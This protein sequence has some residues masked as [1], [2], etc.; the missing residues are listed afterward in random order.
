MLVSLEVIERSRALENRDETRKWAWIFRSFVQWHAIA[1]LLVGLC[2]QQR[3]DLNQDFIQR[4]WKELYHIFGERYRDGGREFLEGRLWLALTKLFHRAKA[5]YEG[6]ESGSNIAAARQVSQHTCAAF[7]LGCAENHENPTPFGDPTPHL[8]DLSRLS[9]PIR[10]LTGVAPEGLPIPLDG[11]ALPPNRSYNANLY[12]NNISFETH[13]S[14]T[15]PYGAS[16]YAV[17]YG[18][19]HA[20]VGSGGVTSFSSLSD[21]DAFQGPS[22][23][24]EWDTVMRDFQFDINSSGGG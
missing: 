3:H 15:G 23:W 16:F 7:H 22:D 19:S 2:Q 24:Q 14:H 8:D 17:N 12:S 1:Y 21:T 11:T 10:G 6:D 4:A 20:A 9:H 18:T 5:V 13:S